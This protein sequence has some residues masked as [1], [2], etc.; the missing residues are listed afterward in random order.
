L[1][2]G[3]KREEI[4]SITAA[5]KSRFQLQTRCDIGCVTYGEFA[6]PGMWR[7]TISIF[8]HGLWRAFATD[9]RIDLHSS[10]LIQGR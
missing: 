8:Q 3:F 9:A 10:D 6:E 2:R 4:N 5:G 1:L 7:S